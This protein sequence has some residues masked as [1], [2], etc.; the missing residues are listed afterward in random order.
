[1]EAPI[2]CTNETPTSKRSD[3]ELH[4]ETIQALF[5]AGLRLEIARDLIDEAPEEA[6]KAL[7]SAIDG[8]VLLIDDLRSRIESLDRRRAWA[9]ERWRRTA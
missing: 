7:D 3:V 4:D 5:G 1:M 8:L 2:T 9:D 6:H